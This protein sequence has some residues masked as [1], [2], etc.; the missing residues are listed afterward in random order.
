[1]AGVEAQRSPQK[2]RR[3]SQNSNGCAATKESFWATHEGATPIEHTLAC[4]SCL[5]F[6]CD[7]MRKTPLQNAM[8]STGE[9]NLDKIPEL[10]L[11]HAERICGKLSLLLNIQV[12]DR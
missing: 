4:A 12:S 10:G 3:I 1:M 8:H 5:Y 11:K 6:F 7:L 9:F 2:T